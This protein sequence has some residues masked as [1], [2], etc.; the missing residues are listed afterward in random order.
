MTNPG[1]EAQIDLQTERQYQSI[2]QLYL[3]CEDILIW[4]NRQNVISSPL[5]ILE[6][7][8]LRHQLR[9]QL[10]EQFPLRWL[11]ETQPNQDWIDSLNSFSDSPHAPQLLRLAK[12]LKNEWRVLCIRDSQR[13][14]S[15]TSAASGPTHAAQKDRSRTT[16]QHVSASEKRN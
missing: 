3:T 15:A 12:Q 5:S 9:E 16:R 1:H 7:E 4:W 11:D 13:A 8:Q 6:I 14:S 2:W 10:R